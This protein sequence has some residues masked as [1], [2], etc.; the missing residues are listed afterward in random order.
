MV[1]EDDDLKR[2]LKSISKKKLTEPRI[3]E[4]TFTKELLSD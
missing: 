2:P 1:F 3:H 4:E